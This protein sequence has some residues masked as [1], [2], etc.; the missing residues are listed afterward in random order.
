MAAQTAPRMYHSTAL[1]LPDGRVLSA[2]QSSGKYENT[3]EIFSPPYRFKGARPVI[4]D[5][6]AT[7]SY[8]AAFAVT[9]P[10]AASIAR[11]VLIKPGAVT[12]SCNFDQRYVQCSFTAS[13]S[14]LS[15]A[16]VPSG[17][18]VPR[19]ARS[20]ASNPGRETVT[21]TVR[22][23]ERPYAVAASPQAIWVAVL[24]RP[25]MMHV[26]AHASAS[27]TISWLLRMCG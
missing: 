12:H 15:A 27:S 17:W 26:P 19:P 1:L 20:P 9:S 23:G 3:G 7:L 21:A 14:T 11:L 13:G 22:V 5:A 16:L 24:G 18:P 25:V 6:P 8:R 10:E 2:G 4:T